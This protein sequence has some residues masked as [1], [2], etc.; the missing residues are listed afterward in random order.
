MLL[1][2]GGMNIGQV[3][4]ATT[5]KGQR[6]KERPLRPSDVLAT[7]SGHWGTAQGFFVVAFTTNRVGAEAGKRKPGDRWQ[8]GFGNPSSADHYPA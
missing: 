7:V 2:R 5:S 6:P 1:S 8:P 3:M 4:G